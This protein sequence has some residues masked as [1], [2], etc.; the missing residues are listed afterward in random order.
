[1]RTVPPQ[2]P[3]S[4]TD[5]TGATLGR[6][7]AEHYG[8]PTAT[9]QVAL[10]G[11]R[12]EASFHTLPSAFERQLDDAGLGHLI[13]DMRHAFQ[14][15]M[16]PQFK[17]AVEEFTGHRGLIP[18]RLPPVAAGI[19]PR[20]ERR[21]RC[22]A[23]PSIRCQRCEEHRRASTDERA[24]IPVITG[25]YVR[26]KASDRTHRAATERGRAGT[27]GRARDT[28]CVTAGGLISAKRARRAVPA[29]RRQARCPRARCRT[30]SDG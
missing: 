13:E 4:S 25:C 28:G 23:S 22:L 7:F 24:S 16:A 14:E 2:V 10:S 12:L 3:E 29:A 26:R 15:A 5:A 9:T 21:E 30:R 8:C 18:L 17:A 19:H 20:F 1:M 27:P 11:G 6:M